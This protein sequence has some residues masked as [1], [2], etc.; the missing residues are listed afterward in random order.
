MVLGTCTLDG[1][2]SCKLECGLF[3]A[4]FLTGRELW[5]QDRAAPAAVLAV[6]DGR[7]WRVERREGEFGTVQFKAAPLV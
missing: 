5:A 6:R 7:L 3:A 4:A 1:G 2:A